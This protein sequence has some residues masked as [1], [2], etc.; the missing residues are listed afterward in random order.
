MQDV[1]KTGKANFRCGLRNYILIQRKPSQIPIH[2][3]REL[4]YSGC[5]GHLN[6]P[7]GYVAYEFFRQE[8]FDKSREYLLRYGWKE[9]AA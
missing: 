9:E 7:A 2:I 4:M 1:F 8:G 6:G 3:D 5:I